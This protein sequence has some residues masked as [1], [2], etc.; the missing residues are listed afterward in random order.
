[1]ESERFSFLEPV[2]A[3]PASAPVLREQ[4]CQPPSAALGVWEGLLQAFEQVSKRVTCVLSL[5]LQETLGVAWGNGKWVQPWEIFHRV[6]SSQRGPAGGC[7]Q[8]ASSLWKNH[9]T[10]GVCAA[11]EAARPGVGTA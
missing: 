3:L 8:T 2:S 6:S 4:A 7:V 1:M 5:G 9:F 10:A 11:A